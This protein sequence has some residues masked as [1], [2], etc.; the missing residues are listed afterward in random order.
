[1]VTGWEDMIDK[2]RHGPLDKT[3]VEAFCAREG[4]TVTAFCDGLALRVAMGFAEGR[5]DYEY[6]DWVMNH[7][8]T[9]MVCQYD[10]VLPPLAF[11]IWEAFDEGE[12][13]HPGD[14][15]EPQPEAL[16]TRPRILEILAKHPPK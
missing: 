13:V 9:L 3:E 2:A 16:Y 7:L 8:E 10:D 14:A 15:S 12:Y 4:I 5:L 6:C 1:M 11:S